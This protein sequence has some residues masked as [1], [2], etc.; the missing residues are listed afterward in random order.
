MA[1]RGADA[2]KQRLLL[3]E[4]EHRLEQKHHIEGTGRDRGDARDLEAARKIAG[5]TAGDF[6][7]AGAGVHP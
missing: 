2:L 3:R 7:G 1:E 4:G 5:A 6:D